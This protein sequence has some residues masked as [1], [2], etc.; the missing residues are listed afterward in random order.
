[1]SALAVSSAYAKGNS[2]PFIG[3][4]PA[5]LLVALLSQRLMQD[6][7]VLKPGPPIARQPREIRERSTSA[8][9][10]YQALAHLFPG[11]SISHPLPS[12]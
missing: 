12:R 8:I 6:L 9:K 11:G 7:R 10:R 5:P 1:M 3:A 2:G 4:P